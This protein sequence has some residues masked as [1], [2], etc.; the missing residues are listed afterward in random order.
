V[1]GGLWGA[2]GLVGGA[3][4]PGVAI[5]AQAAERVREEGAARSKRVVLMPDPTRIASCHRGFERTIPVQADWDEVLILVL[6]PPGTGEPLFAECKDCTEFHHDDDGIML[7]PDDAGK[8]HQV[9]ECL[10]KFRNVAL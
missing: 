4:L 3:I 7:M 2:G 8:L 6:P 1:G 5:H 9:K 10:I